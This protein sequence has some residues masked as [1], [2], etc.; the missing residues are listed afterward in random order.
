[1]F[2][3]SVHLKDMGVKFSK[4]LKGRG[5]GGGGG[6]EEVVFLGGGGGGGWWSWLKFNNLGLELGTN[7]KF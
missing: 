4:I 1:M 3:I 6:G 2:W 5:R 7:L